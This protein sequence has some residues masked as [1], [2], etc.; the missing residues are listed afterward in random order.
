[1]RSTNDISQWRLENSLCPYVR[2]TTKVVNV[3][4]DSGPLPLTEGN[5]ADGVFP[6]YL[7]VMKNAPAKDL[8]M[9]QEY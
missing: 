3:F 9:L 7:Q 1:M 2:V 8:L 4:I 5:Q 6:V